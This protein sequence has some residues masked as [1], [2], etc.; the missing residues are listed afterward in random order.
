[1]TTATRVILVSL[2]ATLLACGTET[3]CDDGLRN[4]DETDVDCGG[5]CATKCGKKAACSV[6]EDCLGSLYCRDATC[7]ANRC[8]D[9]VTCLIACSRSDEACQTDCRES[10]PSATGENASALFTCAETACKNLGEDAVCLT[11]EDE[12]ACRNCM[13]SMSAKGTSCDAEATACEAD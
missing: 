13:V 6:D 12:G 5:S 2:C 10:M 3:T 8:S 9:G 4:G 11:P 1:M 7:W